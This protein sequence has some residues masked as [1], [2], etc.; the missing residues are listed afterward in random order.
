[1]SVP[2][3]EDARPAILTVRD[4]IDDPQVWGRVVEAVSGTHPM[5]GQDPAPALA[6]V[7]RHDL[8]STAKVLPAAATVYGFVPGLEKARAALGAVI[9]EVAP[10]APPVPAA[11]QS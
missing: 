8:G 6:H 4:V 11:Q 7:L 10:Q 9:E 5:F 3:L 1:M 2:G